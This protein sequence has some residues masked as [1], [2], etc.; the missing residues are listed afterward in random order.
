[1]AGMPVQA[2]CHCPPPWSSSL[3][4]FFISSMSKNNFSYPI[5]RDNIFSMIFLEFSHIDADKKKIKKIIFLS[6][7]LAAFSPTFCYGWFF[8][9]RIPCELVNE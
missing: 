9:K 2:C 1:M 5:E 8:E 6:T 3:H 4:I 7:F